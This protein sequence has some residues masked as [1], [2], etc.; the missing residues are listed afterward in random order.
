MLLLLAAF[1]Y[2][3]L[4]SQGDRD[5]NSVQFGHMQADKWRGLK[6]GLI[7]AIPSALLYLFLLLSRLG[8]FWNKFVQLFQILNACFAPTINA[9]MRAQGHDILTTADVGW[10]WILL[11]VFTVA[12]LPLVSWGSYALGYRQ[13][14]ISE[15]LIYKNKKKKRRR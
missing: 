14:S 11:L 15:H 3:I 13:Y 8:L 9:I 6:V 1:P 5:R 12:V 7:A 10:G 2:G 4:W